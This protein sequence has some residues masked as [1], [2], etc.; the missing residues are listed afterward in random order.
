MAQSDR[1]R[2][3]Q[4]LGWKRDEGGSGHRSL[5]DP[6]PDRDARRWRQPSATGR[7][8]AASN[9][10]AH[11]GTVS[12]GLA[13][14]A[15]GLLSAPGREVRRRE[16]VETPTGKVSGDVTT[17]TSHTQTPATGSAGL[18]LLPTISVGSCGRAGVA[19]DLAQGRRS[20]STNRRA[21]QRTSLRVCLNRRV[22]ASRR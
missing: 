6:P 18:E 15:P 3:C 9:A 20:R 22:R 14:K 4:A 16:A 19:G 2:A 5:G 13:T 10:R 17:G 11:I 21:R 8:A 12:Q 1:L 7:P